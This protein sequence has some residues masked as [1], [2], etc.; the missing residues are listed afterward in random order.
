MED[1]VPT[2][3]VALGAALYLVLADRHSHWAGLTALFGVVVVGSLLTTPEPLYWSVTKVA[4]FAL[5]AGAAWLARAVRRRR[6]TDR[7]PEPPSDGRT[8]RST[9]RR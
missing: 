3:T 2:A 8:D 6:A 1:L 4:V 9:T 5:V 7:S